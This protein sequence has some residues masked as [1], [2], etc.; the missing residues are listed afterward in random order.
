MRDTSATGGNL[1]LATAGAALAALLIL[2]TVV[3]PAEYGIDPLGTG[4]S[5]GLL[6]LAEAGPGALSE[7]LE[8]SHR[9]DQMTFE[10]APFE[11]VEYKYRLARGAGMVYSWTASGAVAADFH[12]EPDD[13]PDGFAESFRRGRYSSGGGTYVAPFSGIHGWFWEN[14]GMV[15]VNVELRTR[16]FFTTVIEF[17]D[18]SRSE[19]PLPERK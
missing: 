17:R 19:K 13:A 2:F 12:A 1:A 6:G 3:L 11:S 7:S 8:S 4:E 16:G 14:R 5:L 10:L 18:G 9:A 15:P